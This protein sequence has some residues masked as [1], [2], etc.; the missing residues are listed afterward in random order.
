MRRLT[1]SDILDA[2]PRRHQNMIVLP[3]DL[4]AMKWDQLDFLGW[5]DIGTSRGFMVT[6]HRG[7]LRGL[8]FT[9]ENIPPARSRA[10]MCSLCKTV[11][12]AQGVRLFTASH[13]RAAERRL[14]DYFCD[15]L[16]CSLRVRRLVPL[17]P[18][19]MPETITADEKILRLSVE[20]EGL[21]D[22]YYAHA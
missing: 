2:F 5:I 22:R 6:E 14:G 10:T 17:P 13:P 3:R 20:V 12:S 8:A 18:N 15:D 21:F 1:R 7:E 11:H 4:D 16:L 9:R 19:Q